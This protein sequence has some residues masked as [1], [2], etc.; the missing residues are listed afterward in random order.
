MPEDG[1]RVAATFDSTDVQAAG[2]GAPLPA[3]EVGASSCCSCLREH[4]VVASGRPPPLARKAASFR[5]DHGPAHA[6]WFRG[7]WRQLP[8]LSVS[9]VGAAMA[10]LEDGLYITG[11]VDEVTGE[12]HASAERLADDLGSWRAV[13]WFQMPRAPHGCGAARRL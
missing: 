6:Q 11:G 2:S 10:V 3:L 13:P 4:F 1:W 7:A 5:F 12:F 8:E 9:R